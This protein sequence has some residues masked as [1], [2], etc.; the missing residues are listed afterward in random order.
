MIFPSFS[1]TAGS[2]IIVVMNVIGVNILG[3]LFL[4]GKTGFNNQKG[5]RTN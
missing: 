2:P 4:R 3:Q 1:G 5:E